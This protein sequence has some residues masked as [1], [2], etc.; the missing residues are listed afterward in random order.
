MN[1]QE[2]T[3][4]DVLEAFA[5][6]FSLNPNILKKYLAE[7][8][9]FSVELVDT[10]RELGRLE[11][12][13]ADTSHDDETFLNT[14]FARFKAAQEQVQGQGHQSISEESFKIASKKFK[15]PFSIMLALKERRTDPSTIPNQ[16]LALIAQALAT[17]TRNLEL[18]L[19]G[20]LSISIK[21]NKSDEK[22]TPGVK[23]PFEQI[24][25]DANMSGEELT[26]LIKQSL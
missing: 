20:P 10:S 1:S 12:L 21:S 17:T 3:L 9:Q 11:H 14:S 22:P 4:E 26:Q 15:I 18:Y 24:L 2:F 25:Q 8:P 13:E 16:L 23:V 5:S 7:Y 6:E 19:A